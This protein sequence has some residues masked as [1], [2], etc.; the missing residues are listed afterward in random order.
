MRELPL[1]TLPFS[2]LR[3]DAASRRSLPSAPDLDRS[4]ARVRL[5]VCWARTQEEVRQAQQLRYQ[6]FV[7]EMGARLS[8]PL[9]TPA[10]HD[11]DMFDSFCE[12]LLVRTLDEQGRPAQVIGTYRVLTPEAARRAGGLYSDTEFD[13]TRLRGLR[14]RMVELG[15]SCVHPDHRSGG[16]IMALWGALAEFMVRND[17]D[18]MIGCASVSMRDGGHYAASLWK[19]LQTSHM[20]PIEWQV[21]PRLPL[22][23]DELRQDLQVEPPPLIKGYLRCGARILGRPAWDPDFN[24]ADLPMIMRIADLPARYRRHFLGA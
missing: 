15:R 23:V 13:L 12:H 18:T 17:L 8:P 9:G 6:V 1:P 16:A 7:D 21:R 2:E 5:D 22:P 24:T 11:V 14:S 20:A 3:P 4:A 10:G 19:Q